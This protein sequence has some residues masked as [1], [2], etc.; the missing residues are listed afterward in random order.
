MHLKY[1]PNTS[2]PKQFGKK[3]AALRHGKKI[4]ALF[5]ILL[6]LFLFFRFRGYPFRQIFE[7][8]RMYFSILSQIQ[9]PQFPN[10]ICSVSDYG[11]VGDGTTKNT[12]AIARAIADCSQKGGGKVVFPQGKWFTGPIHL[13][14]NIDLV[15]DNNAEIDFS[16]D[17][18]DYLPVV[19]SRFQGMEY[20]NYSP[21]IYASGCRNV[22]ITGTGKLVGNGAQWRV[23]SH[24]PE[25]PNARKELVAMADSG[26]PVSERIFGEQGG[27]RPSFLQFI[28]CTNVLVQDISIEDGPMWT[29][30]P[31]YSENVVIDNV[32]I[33]TYGINTD[34]VDID[35]SKNVLVEN[36]V[37]SAGDDAISIKSGL[38]TDGL[39]VG[40]PSENIIIR[41]CRM[42]NGHSGISIGSEL[43]GGVHNVVAKNNTFTSTTDGFKIKSL[44]GR[45]GMVEN[46]WLDNITM[47]VD[48]DAISLD[49]FY[50]SRVH[51][52]GGE[53]SVFKNILV[54]NIHVI[55]AQ[56]V[57]SID[58]LDKNHIYNIVV[59]D[60]QGDSKKG[61]SIKNAGSIV[62]N[63]I[64]V[65]AIK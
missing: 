38:G 27:L 56:K 45:G 41:N 36:T 19:F 49:M 7:N 17:R 54:S 55:K 53:A 3:I 46:I 20:Y 2:T 23:W 37:I 18:S 21:L 32:K 24:S 14:D 1:F 31:I 33:N 13:Q 62:M 9:K 48:S 35:S 60:L 28:N 26:V 15:L 51:P 58:S 4:A 22:A 47:S 64:D 39:R 30:H 8:Q 44:E 57:L 65:R 5:F 42:N 63:R 52:A 61:I 12:E 6:A 50:G 34:G 11:A 59:T 40:K 29:I 16:D 25:N 10:R 43:T